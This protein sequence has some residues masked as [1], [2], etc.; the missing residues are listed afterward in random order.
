MLLIL[1]GVL[2]GWELV[3]RGRS[4]QQLGSE[5][6]AFLGAP[7]LGGNLGQGWSGLPTGSTPVSI[8]PNGLG[9][10]NPSP[11]LASPLVGNRAGTA[12]GY[13][14]APAPPPPPP[15]VQAAQVGGGSILSGLGNLIGGAWQSVRNL[16]GGL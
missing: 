2:V 12:A 5:V 8:S 16:L 13:A 1:A 4:L 10:G 3:Y 7:K 14:P 15:P 11:G 6:G 9:S